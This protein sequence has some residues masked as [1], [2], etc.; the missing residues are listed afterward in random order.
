MVEVE[1]DLRARG[2]RDA[3]T[4]RDPPARMPMPVKQGVLESKSKESEICTDT[5]PNSKLS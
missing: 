4:P 5:S 3:E 2:K 1:I